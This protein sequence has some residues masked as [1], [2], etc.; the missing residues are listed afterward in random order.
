MCI[1]DELILFYFISFLYFDVGKIEYAE[2]QS[3]PSM[4]VCKM[5]GTILFFGHYM[6]PPLFLDY[7]IVET[8][9][10]SMKWSVQPVLTEEG[11]KIECRYV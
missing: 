11:F 4:I 2:N 5:M 9:L 7:S 6:T 1:Y 8:L 10:L 3:W